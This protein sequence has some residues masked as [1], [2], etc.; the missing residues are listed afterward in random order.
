MVLAL[1]AGHAFA[2]APGGLEQGAHQEDHRVLSRRVADGVDD[3]GAPTTA[4]PRALKKGE[5]CG[6][7]H[8]EEV[9]EMGK[10]M[11][12]GQRIEPTPPKGKAAV[13]SGHGAGC[14]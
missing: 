6:S 7:C 2:A 11:V 14:A 5:S 13:D 4:A 3:E 1:A 9:V 8:E 10:K 12:T